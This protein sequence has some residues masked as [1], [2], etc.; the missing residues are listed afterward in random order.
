[1]SEPHEPDYGNHFVTFH[2]SIWAEGY[3]SPG[4]SAE[5]DLILTDVD[6]INKDMLDIVRPTH[7][8][9]RRPLS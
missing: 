1:M 3:L 6:L 7:F 2:D 9:A 5:V 4:G 8:Y